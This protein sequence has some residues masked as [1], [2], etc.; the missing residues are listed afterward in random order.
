MLQLMPIPGFVYTPGR[1]SEP[2]AEGEAQEALL[3][4]FA[5]PSRISQSS[6][7]GGST[8]QGLCMLEEKVKKSIRG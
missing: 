6:S 8:S 1:L 3:Q 2:P 4:T 5:S 7:D